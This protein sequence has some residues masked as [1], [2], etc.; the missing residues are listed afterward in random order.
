[1]VDVAQLAIKVDTTDLAR[2]EASL[3]ALQREGVQTEKAMD[4]LG[5]TAQRTGARVRTVG[6]SA[7]AAGRAFQNAAFQ[8]GDF[9][10]QM[11]SG[12]RASV[13][14]AQQLPQLLGGFGIL[15]AALGAVVAIG[16]ALWPV[17]VN[18]ANAARD[19]DDAIEDLGDAVDRLKSPLQVLEMT[20]DQLIAKFGR[21]AS[22]VREFARVQSEL[23][24]ALA[25]SRLSDQIEI[26]DSLAE[27]YR[28]ARAQGPGMVADLEKLS[29]EFGV[30]AS[31]AEDLFFAFVQFDQAGTFAEQEAALTEIVALMQENNFEAEKLPEELQR[32]ISQLISLQREI[33]GAE[34]LMN[35]L[36]GAA[37]GVTIGDPRA[38]DAFGGNLLPGDPGSPT[39]N[40]NGRTRRGGG[41]RSPA[42]TFATDLEALRKRLRTEQEVIQEE[43]DKSM[44][45]LNDRRAQEILGE[46]E[47]RNALLDVEREYQD[48]LS[49]L[50]Q[51]EHA[52]RLQSVAG[53]FGDVASLMQSGSKKLFAIGKAA[54]IAEAT[55][56]GYEAATEAWSKGMKI[57]GPPVAAAFTAASLARTGALISNIASTSIGGGSGGGGGALAAPATP[58]TSPRVAITLTGSENAMYSK[59]QVRDLINA[60]NQEVESGAIVRLA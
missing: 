26:V 13:A 29:R 47:H 8:V 27:G 50:R 57:G 9:A 32:A 15:G 25:R 55:V 53:A 49:M 48:K 4:R 40:A 22:S 44:A 7:G 52:A 20:T 45:L 14:L 35:R 10:T 12:Q 16:G 23:E 43:Y 28:K 41:G 24:I 31:A 36:A 51:Q 11:A 19:F 17:L 56:A 34:E 46:Q 39:A 58:N 6:G 33:A 54:A 42:D 18:N 1:M 2:G 59:Q 5:N 38:L 60:I 30:S 21:A 3:E 37:A